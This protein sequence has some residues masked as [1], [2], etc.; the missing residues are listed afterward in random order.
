MKPNQILEPTE[1]ALIFQNN[2]DSGCISVYFNETFI[3]HLV[4][5]HRNRNGVVLYNGSSQLD[6]RIGYKIRR[7]GEKAA[8]KRVGD[9]LEQ[10][11]PGLMIV[12]DED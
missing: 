4:P 10:K 7:A 5:S 3:G 6:H 2:E 11:Y 8:K 9:S 1:V 12:E